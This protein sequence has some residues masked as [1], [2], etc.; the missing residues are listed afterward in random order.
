VK[1]IKI[2]ISMATETQRAYARL[3]KRF[4]PLQ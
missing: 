1:Q 3:A 2:F 4:T